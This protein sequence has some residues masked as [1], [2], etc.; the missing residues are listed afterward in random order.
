M[1]SS[2]PPE[3]ALAAVPYREDPRDAFVSRNGETLEELA[4]GSRVAT[5][6][7]RRQALVKNIRPDLTVEPLRGNVPTRLAKLD[8]PEGPDAVILAAAGPNRLGL[9][10]RISQH[11]FC[12]NFVSA[13]GQGALALE[14]RTNDQ[15]TVT[16]AEKLNHAGTLL[17]ITAERAL[18]DEVG[19]CSSTS[20]SAHVIVRGKRLDSQP[21]PQRPRA[22]QSSVKISS[23][24]Q[25]TPKISEN[26]WPN[27]SSNAAQK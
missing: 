11:L 4:A 16:A 8:D 27:Y 1:P 20:I 15:V 22:K 18:L 7:A 17:E 23:I 14:S 19:G 24:E 3:F 12:S 25:P 10:D 9:Q 21:S 2:L 26:N 5:G 13:I 6:S